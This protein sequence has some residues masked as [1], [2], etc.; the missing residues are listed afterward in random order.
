VERP[1]PAATTAAN[2]TTASNTVVHFTIDQDR[3]RIWFF[4]DGGGTPVTV[5]KSTRPFSGTV[6]GDQRTMWITDRTGKLVSLAL[7]D[8]VTLNSVFPFPFVK[9][10]DPNRSGEVDVT[11]ISAIFAN[12]NKFAGP[13]DPNN[14]TLLD[15]LTQEKVAHLF[16][17]GFEP[18]AVVETSPGNFQAWLK[19]SRVLP[20]RLSTFAAKTLA[21]RFGGDPRLRRL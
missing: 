18:T 16:R 12:L 15:D 11:D 13:L 17:D 10:C 14:L 8:L 2:G 20:Q 4:P 6:A 5:A 21:E 1:V 3:G 7:P 19:H 9:H